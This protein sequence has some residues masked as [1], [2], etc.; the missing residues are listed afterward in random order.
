MSTKDIK[1]VTVRFYMD[2]EADR[3]AW[4]KLKAL[5]RRYHLSFNQ[6]II[7][8]LSTTDTEHFPHS[9]QVD[10]Q[11]LQ[12]ISTQVAEILKQAVPVLPAYKTESS[13]M[14][15]PKAITPGADDSPPDYSSSH[16]DWS[17]IG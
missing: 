15:E 4:E 14:T 16:V 6:I 2:Y 7:M 5:N 8:A 3:N 9:G 10:T 1:T 11:T 12:Q 17:F 13:Q